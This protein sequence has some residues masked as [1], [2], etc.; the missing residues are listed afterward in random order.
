MFLIVGLEVTFN[1]LVEF[2]ALSVLYLC[3]KF[4]MRVTPVIH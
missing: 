3:T 4:H 2:V 1:T